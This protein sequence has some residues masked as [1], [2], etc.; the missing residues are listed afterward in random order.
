MCR[1]GASTSRSA[2]SS[3]ALVKLLRGAKEFD[4]LWPVARQAL[5]VVGHMRGGAV[6]ATRRVAPTLKGMGL[7]PDDFDKIKTA[8]N[9]T[10]NAKNTLQ[11]D[12]KPFILALDIPGAGYG[13][14]ASLV[15]TQGKFSLL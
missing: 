10:W 14:E 11:R 3:T 6:Q 13:L 8:V 7:T 2:R 9:Y 4:R 5:R 15:Y 1:I 12:R